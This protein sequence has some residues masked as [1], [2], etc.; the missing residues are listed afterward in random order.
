MSEFY[1]PIRQ[2]HIAAVLASG[3][4]FLLRAALAQVG[5]ERWALAPPPRYLS[6]AIDTTLLTAAVLLLAILPP[7]AYA[8]GWLAA[9]LALLPV[10]IGFGWFAIRAQGRGLRLTFFAGA[11]LAYGSMFSIARTHDPLGPL[12]GWF[13]NV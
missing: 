6:Y 10:Y 9:K 13:A 1:G 4:L 12:Q 3:S 8:N 11:A 2:A 7:A 5:R